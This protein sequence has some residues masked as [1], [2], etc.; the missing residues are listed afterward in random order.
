MSISTR[1]RS[2]CGR[3]SSLD[4]T[5]A[6]GIR[7][8]ANGLTTNGDS[9]ARAESERCAL[10]LTCR[11]TLLRM[12]FVASSEVSRIKRNCHLRTS[13]DLRSTVALISG[14]S[15]QQRFLRPYA[16]G[17]DA[18]VLFRETTACG[19][20]SPTNGLTTNG[21]CRPERKQSAALFSDLPSALLR[22]PFVGDLMRAVATPSCWFFRSSGTECCDLEPEA[23]AHLRLD[24]QHPEAAAAGGV[25]EPPRGVVVTDAPVHQRSVVEVRHLARNCGLADVEDP[26]AGA[27]KIHRRELR[28]VSGCRSSDRRSR[29]RAPR[30]S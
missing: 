18:V 4:E 8:P 27:A 28:V 23:R 2:R 22:T 13:A 21:K 1:C 15:T 19:I 11:Q 7:P 16:R 26:E 17:S 14:K 3:E 5:T 24:L 12:L 10:S 20:R 9:Q 25:E 29:G 30:L 6:C